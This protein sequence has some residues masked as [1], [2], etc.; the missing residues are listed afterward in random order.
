MKIFQI[1][2]K[3]DP[4]VEVAKRFG[5]KPL[6]LDEIEVIVSFLIIQ[7][8]LSKLYINLNSSC[9]F[10]LFVKYFCYQMW[11]EHMEKISNISDQLGSHVAMN[12][13]MN[14]E[15]AHSTYSQSFHLV[16]REINKV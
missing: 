8:N 9:I 15:D 2:L 4:E 11:S 7:L 12:I 5:T 13:I 1:V 10:A 3:L 14:L 16:K 6:P